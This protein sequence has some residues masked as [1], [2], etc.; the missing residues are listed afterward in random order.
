MQLIARQ[1]LTSAAASITF[2][3]IP[4]DYTDLLILMSLRDTSTGFNGLL[5]YRYNGVTSGY[6]G[7][8]LFG[9]GSSVGSFAFTTVTSTPASGTWGR[10]ANTGI[11]TSSQTANTFSN[12]SFYIPNYLSSVA[13]SASVDVVLENN[14]TE[15]Y[16]EIDALLSTLTSPITS[17]AFAPE[18]GTGFVANSSFT[19]YGITAGSDG[20]V[21][22]S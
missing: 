20:I 14:G 16:Q 10:A 12:V 6:S 5:A 8:V 19:L 1:E 3:S 11:N 7:R 4:A 9:S 18:S 17:I 13:K 21:A 22:V 15:S 2:S